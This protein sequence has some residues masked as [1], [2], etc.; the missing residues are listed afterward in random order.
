MIQPHAVI[1]HDA[2]IG[3]NS[4]I[5]SQ[6]VLAGGVVVGENTYIALGCEIKELVTIGN[7]TIVSMGTVVN[8]DVSSDVIVRGNPMEIVSKNYL[9]SAF[10]LNRRDA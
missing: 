6:S 5:S 4:I 3:K 8:R 9:K 1:G 10:R 7:N 2:Y